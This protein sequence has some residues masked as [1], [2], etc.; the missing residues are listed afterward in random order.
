ML[1]SAQP[2][3]ALIIVLLLATFG[4]Y[5][6]FVNRTIQYDE[7][8][9]LRHFAVHPGIALLSYTEPN[10]HMLH[11]L[12]V[13]AMTTVGGMSLVAVR[14]PALAMAILSIAMMYRVGCKIGGWQVGFGAAVF[15]ATNVTFAD[16]A[17]NARG[18]TLAIFLTLALVDQVF[19][20]LPKQTRLYRYRLL[21]T[22][23]ALIL[24]LPTMVVLVA[25]VFLW[26]VF[27]SRVQRNYL[28]AVP[29]VVI[30]SVGAVLFYL[31]AVLAGSLAHNA[32][33]FGYHELNPLLSE[34]LA[35]IF[36]TPLVGVIL[37][38]ACAVG[39]TLL[40]ARSR[41]SVLGQILLSIAGTAVTAN[42]VQYVL[43]KQ[44][45]YGRNYFYVLPLVCVVAAFGMA[46]IH[47]KGAVIIALVVCVAAFF[48]LRGAL[49]APTF[50]DQLLERF[51]TLLTPEDMILIGNFADEPMFYILQQRGEWDR[52]RLGADKKRLLVITEASN[53]VMP[54]IEVYQIDAYIDKDSCEPSDDARWLPFVAYECAFT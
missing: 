15:L 1:Q 28:L 16:Y 52:L 12:L 40:L 14:F 42:L 8:Y 50:V 46:A 45:F 9:T 7:A 27:P 2:H 51:E 30:G 48:P 44:V 20:S 26:L 43:L 32:G 47:R 4:F 25:G 5:L 34:W 39:L 13:W 35:I 17:V 23:F 54:L 10:N 41:G 29:P 53:H 11:S 49:S 19:V 36:G 38:A 37:L 33:R 22:C 3:R 21:L 6:S 24:T 31:P 18:Y